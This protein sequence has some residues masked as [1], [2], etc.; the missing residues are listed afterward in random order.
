M[1]Y[2]NMLHVI[3]LENENVILHTSD[4]KYDYQILSEC[5]EKYEFANKN[6]P[7]LFLESIPITHDLDI[8]ER[9]KYY[10]KYYGINHV[11]GGSYNDISN[12][13]YEELMKEFSKN[14][15][16]ILVDEL[17]FFEYENTR[18]TIDR[19]I[20]DSI[21][22][23]MDT[24][25]MK[26]DIYKYNE[27]YPNTIIEPI[28]LFF[29]EHGVKKYSSSLMGLY[30]ISNKNINPKMQSEYADYIKNPSE[31]F[32]PLFFSNIEIT[33]QDISIAKSVCDYF[34]YLTYCI[35]NKYEELEFDVSDNSN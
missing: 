9:V 10:M 32:Y 3:L 27:T 4:A 13:Q 22:W 19:S 14:D 5:A 12:E 6:K 35:I 8:D 7:L 25:Q 11:R 24:I 20:I 18:Y 33:A 29:S 21:Q 15:T 31:L 26:H 2:I 17:K 28:T 1:Y 23:L 16:K 34:E 30:A